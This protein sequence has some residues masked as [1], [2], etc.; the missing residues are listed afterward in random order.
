MSLKGHLQLTQGDFTLETGN[1]S[2]PSQGLTA[3]FGH[4]G[5][6]KTT[7][8]RALAGFEPKA[9]G[10][11]WY[12]DQVWLNNHQ[13]LPVHQRGLGYVF[14]EASL[15]AHLNVEQNLRY[16]LKRT[17]QP[18]SIPFEQ[19]VDWLG[20]ASLLKR[21]VT[22]LSGGE[23]Q[24]VAIGRTLLAQPK[25]LFM[26]EPMAAL[27]VLAKRSI[28]P[29][30]ERLRDE[31]KIP[32]IY[33]THSP[34][35]VE[36]LADTVVFMD[37]GKITAIEPIADALNRA[38]TPLYQQADL[39]AVL[40]ATVIEQVAE[41]GL[42]R[43][44]VGSENLWVPAVSET[45]GQ[46]LRVVIA[47]QQVSL[48]AEKPAMT[49]MLNHLNVMIERI[50]PQNE[51]SLKVQCKIANTPWPLLAQI[52]RRSAKQ[53]NLQPQQQWVAAIKSVSILN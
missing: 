7:F 27:D 29:Y 24:R 21:E 31:L 33:I 40:P 5:S 15:F 23:K 52:T 43:L 16:G 42:T 3:I 36:R 41:E 50:D 44:A 49:S 48:M 38:D 9:S 35:E 26:D 34:E 18:I 13:A 11:I 39:R 28:M 20:L 14:Q 4:S 1:F 37:K 10:K 53:L 47:A 17:K 22:A 8:L 30:L 51:Y 19:V 6:G 32:I 12:F 46:K 45:L 2:F 25:V